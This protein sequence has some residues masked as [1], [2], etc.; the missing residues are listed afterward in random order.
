VHDDRLRARHDS[1]AKLAPWTL[2]VVQGSAGFADIPD[3]GRARSDEFVDAATNQ[4]VCVVS[5]RA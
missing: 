5:S 4:W 3:L 1:S 2:E